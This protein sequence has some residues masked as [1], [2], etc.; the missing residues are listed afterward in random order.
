MLVRLYYVLIYVSRQEMRRSTQGSDVQWGILSPNESFEVA[1]PV[2]RSGDR[3]VD[4][5]F[6]S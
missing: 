5:A 3:V 2:S 1:Q 4:H 6:G